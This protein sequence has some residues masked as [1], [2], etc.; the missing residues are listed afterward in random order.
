MELL[1][2]GEPAASTAAAYESYRSLFVELIDMGYAAKE[3][4]NPDLWKDVR[5]L[6]EGTDVY[7]GYARVTAEIER[8]DV[9]RYLDYVED[10]DSVVI[11]GAGIR[12]NAIYALLRNN[13]EDNIKAFC[14]NDTAKVGTMRY[15]TEVIAPDE[16]VEKYRKAMYIISSPSMYEQARSQLYAH[17]IPDKQIAAYPL[18][19]HPLF[20]TNRMVIRNR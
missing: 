14:D 17:G 7:L 11:F 5:L 6:S 19:V 13:G 10:K 4:M 2:W 12:G 15:G 20:C 8:E 3:G 16:A 1:K 18:S 9:L